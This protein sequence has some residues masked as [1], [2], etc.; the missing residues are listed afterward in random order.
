MIGYHN[1]SSVLTLLVLLTVASLLHLSSPNPINTPGD[2]NILHRNTPP[3]LMV[4]DDRERRYKERQSLQKDEEE[5]EEELFRDVDPKTL[6]AVLLEALNHSQV[7]RKKE[8]EEHDGMVKEIKAERGEVKKEEEYRQVRAMEGAERDRDGRQELEL[9]MATQGKEQEREE[10]EERKKTQ[11]E[12]EKMTEKVTSRTTSQTVQVQT[13]SPDRRGGNGKG[14]APQHGPTSSE[15]SS[16]EEEEQ[17]SPEE[18]KSLETMMKEFPRLDTATKRKG[19]LE[20]NQRESRGYSIHNEIIPIN[21]GSNL[22]MSKKK[23]KWQEETQKALNFPAFRGGNFMDDFEKSKYAAQSQPPAEQEV[24][25]E[26]ELEDGEEKEDEEVLSPEE[27]EARAKAEQE[28]MRRQAAEAQRAKMEEEKLADIASDM[29]LRYMVKQN[30]GNKKYSSSLSNAAEDKRSD[31]EQEAMEEDDIDP[32]TI[33]KLIEISSKLHL[34]ADDV[35]DIIS[36][37][38]KKKKKDVPPELTSHWQQPLTSLSSSFSST[39]GFSASQIPTSQ[40]NFPVSKQSSP[41]FNLPKTWF[42]EKTSTKSQDNWSKP[43]NP[44]L[45]NQNLWS[46]PQKLMSSKQD[47]WLKSPKSVW[48][49]YPSYPYIYPFYYQRKPYPDYYPIYFPPPPRPKPRYYIPKPALTLNNFLGNSVD[50]AHTFPP[51]RRYHS[52]VQPRLRKPPTGLQQKPYYTSYPLPQYPLP[53]QPVPIPNPHS[54]PRMLVISPQQKQ[55]YYSA[56]APVVTRNEDYYV[57]GKQSDSSNHN[58][59]EKYIQ[60]ILMKRPKMLD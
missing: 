30:N 2:I 50:D 42:L 54:P 39:N 40:N 58:D 41:A 22:A 45:A 59:L 35:V 27:E 12:E 15:Q 52:W 55:I 13:Q 33:D 19:D 60:Q 23:L 32:R 43:A 7:E 10:E 48:T 3:G 47:L 8:G 56:L 51:K 25:E 11:E 6:A 38:E 9:L 44:L 5:A 49:G 18:L 24:M 46:K 53:F 17:L 36:D 26:D 37:V 21:K 34:P 16:N 57:A 14:A 20:Q 28:E 1:A 31:E 29:L 4:S